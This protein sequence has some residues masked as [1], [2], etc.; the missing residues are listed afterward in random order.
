MLCPPAEEVRNFV[1]GFF[2]SRERYLAL[3]DEEASPLYVLEPDV[4]ALRAR[5]F[6][7]AFEDCFPDCCF[8]FAVKSNNHPVVSQTVLNAGFGLEVS[9]GKELEA[10]LALGAE[11]ILFTG[12]GKTAGELALAAENSERVTILMDGFREL[13]AAEKAAA[14]KGVALDAGVRLTTNPEGIWRKFGIPLRDLAGFFTEAAQCSHIHL[15]GLQFHT[16]WN[17]TPRAQTDF[18]ALLGA[19]LAAFPTHFTGRIQFIDIGGGYWP[20]PGEWVQTAPANGSAPG[21]AGFP[22]GC[23]AA[24]VFHPAAPIEAFAEQ[25]CA[26]LREHLEFLLPFRVCCEPGRW[27]CSDGMHLMMTVVDGK[28][29]DLVITDSG[30][31]AIGWERF[32]TEYFPI[33]N[34]AR[35]S[36]EEKPCL[37][38]GS[39]CT[40]HDLF[41]YSYFGD[42]LQIGDV[43]FIPCQGAYTYSLKQEFIKPVLRVIA[44]SNRAATYEIQILGDALLPGLS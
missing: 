17:L 41:G 27:I 33:L 30:I 13:H 26:A 6:R 43:L 5:R 21:G 35:P 3:L 11:D 1:R 34:L 2:E 20:Q 9:S 10:A 16:S 32:D 38:C 23:P 15:R 12:P 44:V 19:E 37:I 22:G 24:P 14:A 7:R 29:P 18:I 42:D 40:P 4:L 8:Y 36:L 31:H 25:L 28:A 39:L